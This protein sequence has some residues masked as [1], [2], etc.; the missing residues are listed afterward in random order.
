MKNTP[1]ST[2]DFTKITAILGDYFEGLYHADV[3]QL[4]AIFHPHS[5]LI[6]PGNRRSVKKW[7]TD[8]ASRDVPAKLHQPFNFEI[9]A[10]DVV[11]D[12][13]MAK[14]KCPLFDFNYIDFLGLLKEDGQWRIISK[15]YTD[16]KDKT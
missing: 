4:T 14:V 9:L 13:A 8:V 16:I 5:Q 15:M 1:K 3:E 10:I 12:Q 11:Q 7:L 6:A 2:T